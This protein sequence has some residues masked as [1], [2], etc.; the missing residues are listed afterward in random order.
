MSQNPPSEGKW[1]A[2]SYDQ[3]HPFVW[4][5][6]AGVV[7]LLAPQAGESV[8]DLGCGTG[9]LTAQI[10]ASGARV[11]GFD[12]SP[13]MLQ[14]ARA[15]HPGLDFRL[16]DARD[17][18]FPERFDAVFSNAALHWIHEPTRAIE[19]VAHHL[20]PGGRFVAEM[21]GR[22]NVAALETALRDA[23]RALGLPRF[24]DFNYFPRLGEYAGLLEAG[25]FEVAFATLFDRPTP[26]DGPRGARNWLVQFRGAY[27]DALDDAAREAVLDEAET[28]LRPILHREGGWFADYRR[29]RFMAVKLD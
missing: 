3:N 19:R 6:G 9:H 12:A 17:F 28:R 24:G 2:N 29:L 23:A 15:G 7:E 21:G 1:N 13:E 18:D 10:A 20:K 27:L 14:K 8:L 16:A 5:M 4:Q 26:L 22:G 25:G 11:V